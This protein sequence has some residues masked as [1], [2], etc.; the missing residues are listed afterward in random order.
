MTDFSTTRIRCS[1]IGS[2]MSNGRGSFT[3]KDGITLKT[4]QEKE[5]LTEKQIISIE[6]L[7]AKQAE[8]ELMSE[9]CKKYLIRTYA[10]EKYR[11]IK[12]EPVTKQ[13]V[14]GI[15]CEEDSIDLFARVEKKIYNKNTER[16]KN[17]FLSGTPDLYDSDSVMTSNEIIDI[18]SSWDINTFLSNVDGPLN[19]MYYWQ[20]QGYMSLSGA[21]TGTIAYCLVNTP[22]EIIED[23]KR[24]LMY[25]MNVATDENTEY[26]LAAAA[27]EFNMRFDDIPIEERVLRFSVERNDNDIDRIF[28]R[29]K[30]CRTFLSEFEQK[31]LFFTKHHR[32]EK[33]S[34]IKDGIRNTNSTEC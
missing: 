11:R 23:E 14:K 34:V 10:L 13:M 18:K 17:E 33:L 28:E 29:V 21:K 27:L 7:V 25:K 16:I 4:L 24:K 30:K 9:G 8:G 22:D 2:I 1:A 20:L 31:H 12:E 15:V 5:K 26:K 32:K 19:P 6:A 3:T